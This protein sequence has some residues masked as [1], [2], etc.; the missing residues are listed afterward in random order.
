MVNKFRFSLISVITILLGFAHFS[1][2]LGFS[3]AGYKSSPQQIEIL[4]YNTQNLYYIYGLEEK[5]EHR[6][7]DFFDFLNSNKNLDIICAQE[8]GLRS[9]ELWNKKMPFPHFYAPEKVGPVIFSKYPINNKGQI[10][11]STST[12]NSCLWA[13]IDVSGSTF[14]VYNLHMQSNKITRTAERVIEKGNLQTRETWDGVLSIIKRY[15]NN[16]AVRIEHAER[17]REHMLDSPY[18]IILAGDFNDVPQSYL[19]HILSRGLSDSFVE[20]GSGFGTTFAGKKPALRIDYILTG[21]KIEILNHEII[22]KDYSDHFA[23]KSILKLKD[24]P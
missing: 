13:D 18:P 23:I 9:I 14:R 10:H 19:Y 3:S 2:F 15:K 21:P 20:Q 4:S 24:L 12:V 11:S 16:A 1:G 17:I 22:K 7:K 8:L 6:S 5:R